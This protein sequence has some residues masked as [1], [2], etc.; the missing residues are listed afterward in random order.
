M[1]DK[2]LYEYIVKE[3][4]GGPHCNKC[5]ICGKVGNDRSNLRKH[6]ENAHFNGVFSYECKYCHSIFG[7]R[8]K[9]NHHVTAAHKSFT[10]YWDLYFLEIYIV[11]GT[12][13]GFFMPAPSRGQAALRLYREGAWVWSTGTQM[14][15]LW[16]NWQW[17]RKPEETCWECPFPGDFF[18]YMQILPPTCSCIPNKDKA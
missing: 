4:E 18:I 17:P 15:P 7:T 1:D 8:T 16:K 12:T 5:T 3:P 10:A 14:Y 2:Q 11:A 13:K 9:L 6:V